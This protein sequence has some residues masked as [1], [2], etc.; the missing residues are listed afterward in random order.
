MTIGEQQ[1]LDVLTFLPIFAF[2]VPWLREGTSGHNLAL[3]LNIP[4]ESSRVPAVVCSN[5]HLLL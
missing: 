5:F 1:L 2:V 3:S 4:S